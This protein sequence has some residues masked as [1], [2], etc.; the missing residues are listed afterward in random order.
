LN[1]DGD[2][3]EPTL[4]GSLGGGSG[5]GGGGAKR[6]RAVDVSCGLNHTVVL[7]EE[8]LERMEAS[9]GETYMPF[10]RSLIRGFV[11]LL[12]DTWFGTCPNNTCMYPPR[13]EQARISR[14]SLLR[15]DA[16]W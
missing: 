2:F 16:G 1:N 8:W 13:E 7:V 15:T 9:V 6:R 14:I 4:V 3:W 10:R 12:S 11:R 5:G